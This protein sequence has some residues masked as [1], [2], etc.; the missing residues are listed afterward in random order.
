M[1]LILL[2]SICCAAQDESLLLGP[3]DMIS[4]QVLEA[5]E[6]TQHV[7]ITDSGEIA[8]VVGGKAKVGGLTPEQAAV[9]IA[10]VLKS[11]DYVL[12]PHVTVVVDQYATSNVTVTGQVQH[13]GTYTIT[14]PRTVMDVLALAGGTTELAD[15]RI[16][17]ER[18]GSR[19]RVEY[20]LSNQAKTAL[21]NNAKVY[22]GDIVVVPKIDIVYVLGDV[23]RPGGYPM[24]TN[25]GKMSMLQAIGMAGSRLPSA[26][27]SQTRLIR[28]LADGSHIETK[29]DLAKLEKGQEAD[30]ALQA[31]DI[32][33]VPFSFIKNIGTNLSGVVAAAA[34]AAII[35][36]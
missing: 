33:Y 15:R 29:L 1:I 4:V 31:D 7:R 3:G 12:N 25:D 5:P 26:K 10:D 9:A 11:G 24:A 8:L 21:D 28:K 32:V 27:T 20:F 18:H 30:I 17:I 23:S 36:H 19:L 34:S 35:V 6:L 14:T 22:P 2:G 16:T 13:P